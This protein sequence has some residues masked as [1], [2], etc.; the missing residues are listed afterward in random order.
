MLSRKLFQ[1]GQ[2]LAVY[3]PKGITSHDVIVKL[4]QATGTARIGHAGTLDPMAEGVLVVGI[5]RSATKQL[6]KFLKTDKEYQAEITFGQ[7]TD[8]YDALGKTI[9]TSNCWLKLSKRQIQTS[10]KQFIGQINQNPPPYSAKKISGQKSYELARKGLKVDLKPA[11]VAIYSA[12]LISWQPPKLIIEV[13]CSSGTYI[14]SLA[15]DLGQ[16]LNCPAHLSAL[17]RTRVG[18]FDV[19]RCQR[20]A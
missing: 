15:F 16:K 19:T 20:I 13:V 5:G 12:K 7:A 17:V 2:L 9:K 4:R 10:L 14:R 6:S 8:T 3:K 18:D 11:S 1:E